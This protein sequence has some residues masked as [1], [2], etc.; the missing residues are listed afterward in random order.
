MGWLQ[1]N[2]V[3]LGTFTTTAVMVVGLWWRVLRTVQTDIGKVGGA[4]QEVRLETEKLRMETEKLGAETEKLGAETEKLGVEIEKVRMEGR[5]AHASIGAKIIEVREGLGAEI[6]EVREGLGAEIAGVREGLS[7]EITGVREGLGAEITGVRE[8]LGEIRG[9]LK[10]VT[11]SIDT[12]REDFRA[13]VFGS[14]G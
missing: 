13:H 3:V 6:A 2:G 12:L 7:A 4:V 1:E 14:G 9:E 11:R 5:E 10:G 8:G